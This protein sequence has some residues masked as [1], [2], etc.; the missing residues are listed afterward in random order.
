MAYHYD[1][2]VA[3]RRQSKPGLTTTE[4]DAFEQ[5]MRPV[6][7]SLEEDGELTQPIR[8]MVQQ[9]LGEQIHHMRDLRGVDP[10]YANN[11]PEQ[12]EIM[13]SRGPTGHDLLNFMVMPGRA[14]QGKKDEYQTYS[15]HN[16][17]RDAGLEQGS[18]AD[19]LHPLLK[20][21]NESSELPFDKR[22]ELLDR[23]QS[24]IVPLYK[25][26][27]NDALTEYETRFAGQAI[28]SVLR[29]MK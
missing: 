17:L 6:I 23:Y 5:Q 10:L 28:D 24:E 13:R 2:P 19:K 18:A 3:T 21:I 14:H 15:V 27:I 26:A 22:L 8:Q 16:R 4:V 11:N 9:G 1:R 20:Q 12:N 29:G 7:A 25:D